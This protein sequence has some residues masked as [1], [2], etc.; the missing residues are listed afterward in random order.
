MA[1]DGLEFYLHSI[2]LFTFIQVQEKVNLG[3]EVMDS[4]PNIVISLLFNV[5]QN[6]PLVW[7]S[8]LTSVGMF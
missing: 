5:E 2:L 1:R 7:A 4:C 8:L 6:T 3:R